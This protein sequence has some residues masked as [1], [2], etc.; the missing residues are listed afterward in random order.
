MVMQVRNLKRLST[1]TITAIR[2]QAKQLKIE[3]L[4]GAQ[5]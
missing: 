5:Q 4:Q 1:E 3:S 2:N